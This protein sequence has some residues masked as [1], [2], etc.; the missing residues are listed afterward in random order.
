M[1]EEFEKVSAL[2]MRSFVGD[3][4]LVIGQREAR[5]TNHFEKFIY[6]D[7]RDRLRSYQI[8]RWISS[9]I[10][11]DNDTKTDSEAA[12]HRQTI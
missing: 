1:E 4:Q 3:L 8:Q 2:R 6:R 12:G 10:S 11:P 5:S 9:L 7:T